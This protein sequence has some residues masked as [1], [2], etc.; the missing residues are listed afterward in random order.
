MI[1]KIKNKLLFLC[2]FFLLL[3]ISNLSYSQ[4][5]T[6]GVNNVAILSGDKLQGYQDIISNKKPKKNND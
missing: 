1:S 4:T 3:S 5:L 2:G 6:K